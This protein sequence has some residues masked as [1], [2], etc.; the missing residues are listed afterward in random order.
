M[1]NKVLI[2]DD[3]KFNRQILAGVLHGEYEIME[4]SNGREALDVLAKHQQDVAALLLDIVMPEMDGITML[5]VMNEK[6]LLGDYPVLIVTSEQDMQ[7]VGECFEYGISDFIRKPVNTAFVKQRVNK[8]VELYIQRNEFRQR[9]EKQT[10]T[11]RNQYKLLQMQA[12]QLKKNNENIIHVL[13][14]IVEFR[15]TESNDHIESIMKFTEILA[16]HV[17]NEYPQY[18]LTEEKIRAI[19]SASALHDVG[20][21]LIP[22]SILL[23]P[24][25]LTDDEFEYMKS[26]SIRG[27][28]IIDQ[29]TGDWNQEYVQYSREITRYHHE[30]Y[31]GSGYPDGLIGE[32]IPI[33]AQI[34]SLADCYE[35]LISE[36]VYKGA[37]S[38]EK[39]FQMIIRGE[40]GLFSPRLMEC[41]RSAKEEMEQYAAQ[42]NINLTEE[43]EE[44][45]S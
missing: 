37:Y 26:H 29:I 43:T 2:V 30:K 24:G 15:N 20:K 3:M 31:D 27:C 33:S 11:L 34:V 6:K 17:M 21:I 8:L 38:P 19:T 45:T 35:A 25:K 13:G 18:G 36:S 7:V 42:R 16:T 28:N 22:D 39:A 12:E 44:S 40:C 32:D 23:K 9:V 14:T 4:A 41:F 5:K 1:R 10:A